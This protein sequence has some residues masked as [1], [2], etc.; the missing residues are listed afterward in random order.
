MRANTFI[1]SW[2]GGKDSCL[3]LDRAKE[4]GLEPAGLFTM[5][6]EGGERSRSHGLTHAVLRA[7]AESLDLRLFTNNATWP[8]YEGVFIDAWREFRLRGIPTGVFGDIDIDENRAWVQRVCSAADM[9]PLHPLW[10]APRRTLLEEFIDKGY[11]ATV[12]AVRDGVLDR[13]FLG[14]SVDRRLIDEF[15]RLGIDA[16]GEHGEYHTVVTDGPLFHYPLHLVQGES[17]CR[18]GVWFLDVTPVRDTPRVVERS[19]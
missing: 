11:R 9:R 16:C 7:Q 8:D 13:S 10:Q 15:E 3:A 6:M 5:F 4:S 18:S 2:S 19:R 12:I 1:T 17:T 14:R